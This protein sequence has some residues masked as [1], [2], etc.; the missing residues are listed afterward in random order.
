MLKTVGNPSTR[1]G[2]QTIDNGNLIIGTAGQGIDFFADPSTAGMTSKL[3]DD[4]EEGT[5][6]PTFAGLT[7]GDGIVWG[8]YTKIGRIVTF[9]LGFQYGSTSSIT[10][11]IGDISGLPFVT[12]NPATNSFQLA[13]GAIFKP[14]DGWYSIMSNLSSNN[15]QLFVTSTLAGVV[16]TAAT[17]TTFAANTTLVLS[18][19]YET[20]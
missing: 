9:Q 15:T 12:V 6:T 1:F 2:D 14:G 13:M 11:S 20:V 17:P 5:F 7:I 18:T 10:G 19:T 8:R 3:F 4:Y 16:I